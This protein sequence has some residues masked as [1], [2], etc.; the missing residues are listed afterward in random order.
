MVRRDIDEAIAGLA[1][2]Q[3][4]VFTRQQALVLGATPRMVERRV[5]A[6][7]WQPRAVGVYTLLGVPPSW[8]TELFVATLAPSCRVAVSHE[9]AAVL[10]G[11]T[12]FSGEPV[13][14]TV[15]HA[16]SRIDHVGSVH[17]SRRLYEDHLTTIDGLPVTTV[18]RTIVDLAGHHRRGRIEMVFDRAVAA[19]QM[20]FAS[21][22]AT[23][24]DLACRGR[25][26]VGLL[27]SVLAER[28]ATYTPPA[29][30]AESMLL[31]VL[32]LGGLPRPVLQFPHPAPGYD[33]RRV[34]A[35]Y[36][37]ARLLIEVD[38]ATWHGGWADRRRDLARDRAAL[39]VGYRTIRVDK[40]TLDDDPAGFVAEV[41]SALGRAA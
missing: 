33:G 11:L 5:A 7:R 22:C 27:R 28:D 12:T 15:E 18:E 30:E 6:G 25:R 41:R 40:K 4:G 34:D 17:Q 23:F 39:A 9:A 29:S 35:A 1:M 24:D 3:A 2:R 37:Q 26:G 32:R 16:Q 14:V 38:S 10:H 13:I 36:P 21:F 8:R 31:R 19:G 20:T